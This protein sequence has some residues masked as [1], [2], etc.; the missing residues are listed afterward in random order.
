M[1]HAYTWWP[2]RYGA[3]DERGSLN[4]ITPEKIV[5]ASR[6]VQKGEVYDL[7]RVLHADVPRFEGRYWQQTLISSSHIIN[8]RRPDGLSDGWGQNRINW[9]T[10]LVTGTMQIGTHLDALNH[11]QIGDRFYNGFQARD[12]V[13]EW[14]T[15]KLGIE[16]VPQVITHG[17]LVDIAR[18][19]GVT[20]MNEGEAITAKDIEGALES[21]GVSA[22]QGDVLL[23]HTGWGALWES[24]PTRY[25]SGEPGIGMDAAEW[26]VEKRIAMTGADTW[27][28]GVVPGEDPERPFVVPQMLN[29][30]HGMFIMENLDTS[31]LAAE[32]VYEFMFVLTHYKTRGSTAAWISPIAVI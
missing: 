18:Y 24:D 9:I 26:L 31:M 19:R 28:Y 10:E 1:S 6:L 30:K 3:D 5:A 25:T 21:Q 13:E 15:N 14:G 12:I 22:G 8:P 29:A 4:E 17:V 16:S 20:Q 7:G 2:S 23:I 32:K 11:L 27:S